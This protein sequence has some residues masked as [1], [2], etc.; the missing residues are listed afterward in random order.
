VRRFR[1]ITD[2]G[3]EKIAP[4]LAAWGFP[5]ALGEGELGASTWVRY[6]QDVIWWLTQVRDTLDANFHIVVRPEAR[7]T[8]EEELFFAVVY[9]TAEY[10][11]YERLCAVPS[12]P[13]VGNRL[14]RLGWSHNALGYY[15]K[16]LGDE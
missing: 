8:I 3:L 7:G 9:A 13:V 4:D 16:L 1:E 6:G 5:R 11:G 15:T 12:E 14:I 10:L 2:A